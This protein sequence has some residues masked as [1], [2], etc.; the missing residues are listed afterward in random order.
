MSEADITIRVEGPNDVSRKSV[1]EVLAK[2]AARA[3]LA[4]ER[5]AFVLHVSGANAKELQQFFVAAQ[6]AI[7]ADASIRID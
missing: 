6:G 3:G 4:A 1:V 7:A 2:R 5:V